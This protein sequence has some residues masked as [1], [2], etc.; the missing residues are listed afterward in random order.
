[1]YKIVR[2]KCN[3][4]GKIRGVIPSDKINTRILGQYIKA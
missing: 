1:M 3:C 2:N 4:I